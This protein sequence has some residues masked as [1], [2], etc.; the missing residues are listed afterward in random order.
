M[1][2]ARNDP[3]VIDLLAQEDSFEALA[4]ACGMS[5]E[6]FLR[7]W[8]KGAAYADKHWADNPGERSVGHTY[9]EHS[10]TTQD[11]RFTWTDQ[12]EI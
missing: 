3:T 12:E 5:R 8:N 11:G 10:F 6:D 1:S 4:R 7:E 9:K 2:D